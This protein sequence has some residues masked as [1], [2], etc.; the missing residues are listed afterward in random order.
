[1]KYEKWLKKWEN[2]EQ[3]IYFFCILADEMRRV[4][5]NR[6]KKI[7]LQPLSREKRL[8]EWDEKRIGK[9]SLYT[10]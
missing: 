5:K 8:R 4:V 3:K 7:Y 10:L 9:I 2:F 1:M 6:K